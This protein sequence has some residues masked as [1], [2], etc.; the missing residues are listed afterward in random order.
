[1]AAQFCLDKHGQRLSAYASTRAIGRLYV[2]VH[3]SRHARAPATPEERSLAAGLLACLA[4][5]QSLVAPRQLALALSQAAGLGVRTQDAAVLSA[6][7]RRLEVAAP[8]LYQAELGPATQALLRIHAARG[9][10][11]RAGRRRRPPRA[12]ARGRRTQ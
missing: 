5:T 4:A 3:D 9:A 1:M 11:R 7:A 10:P 8:L 12:P 6:L 2:L